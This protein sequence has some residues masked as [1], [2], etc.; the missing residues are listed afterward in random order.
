MSNLFLKIFSLKNNYYNVKFYNTYTYEYIYICIKD[1]FGNV[2]NEQKIMILIEWII[3][4][5]SIFVEFIFPV[6][7]NGKNQK[8]KIEVILY[9][10]CFLLFLWLPEHTIIIQ[11]SGT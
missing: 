11:F 7:N 5:K 1:N 4:S 9:W 3:F 6:N 10:N 2:P 8:K